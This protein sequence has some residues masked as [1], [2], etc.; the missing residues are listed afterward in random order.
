MS[1]MAIV[2]PLIMYSP[3][4]LIFTIT[5]CLALVSLFAFGVDNFITL[6]FANVDTMRK[7]N[8]SINRISFNAPACS[9]GCDLRRLFRFILNFEFYIEA[10]YFIVSDFRIRTKRSFL[11][12]AQEPYARMSIIVPMPG[13]Q[14][15]IT[16]LVP[17]KY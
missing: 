14:L 17:A 15:L 13:P 8:K 5:V 1:V 10:R 3:F 2:L 11:I 9:S 6:G 4:G 12:A 16:V 7:K